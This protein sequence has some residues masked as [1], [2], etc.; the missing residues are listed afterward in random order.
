MYSHAIAT[1]FLTEVSG[2][3]DPER[4][5]KVDA[6]LPKALKIILTAQ[7][8]QKTDPRHASGW[9]YQR[10]SADSDLSHAEVMHR[11]SRALALGAKEA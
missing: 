4:Q 6:V 1:L 2:M 3:V 10:G 5:K 11:A 9:R 7:A 8:V